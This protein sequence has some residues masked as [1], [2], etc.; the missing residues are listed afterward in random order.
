M[1]IAL[2]SMR[3]PSP[4]GVGVYTL[5]VRILKLKYKLAAARALLD[6]EGY[7]AEEIAL[8]SMKIAADVCVYTN[9]NFQI[10]KINFEK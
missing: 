8:K 4:L 1:G 2:K 6:V 5:I 7:G 9:S 10:E 3:V